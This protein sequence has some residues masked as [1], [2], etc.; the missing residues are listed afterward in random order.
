[1]L[2]LRLRPNKFLLLFIFFFILTGVFCASARRDIEEL[3]RR[4]REFAERSQ[5]KESSTNI[6]QEI[7]SALEETTTQPVSRFVSDTPQTLDQREQR[8]VDFHMRAANRNF[9]RRDYSR[10]INSLEQVFE[11]DPANAGGRFMRAVMAARNNEYTLA[12]H[13]ILIAKEKDSDNEKINLFINNLE[14]VKPRPTNMPSVPGIYRSMPSHMSEKIFD[15]IELLLND[16]C[17]IYIVE[18]SADQI[19]SLAGNSHRVNF[20][21]RFSRPP[22]EIDVVDLLS[23]AAGQRAI[24]ASKST[25]LLEYDFEFN[26]IDLPA[27][28]QNVRPAADLNAFVSTTAEELDVALRGSTETVLDNNVLQIVYDISARD[29]ETI[30]SFLRR[31]SPYAH[32]FKIKNMRLAGIPRSGQVIWRGDIKINFK[33]P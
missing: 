28:N 32:D 2:W 25:D 10:A 17:S 30:N 13:N 8:H 14:T 33:T 18:F 26:I 11:V 12:W 5:G 27:S 22:E 19:N 6:R 21:V 24:V 3:Q 16:R 7:E 20:Q 1:M 29:F 4:A 15:V 31:L 9:M 23:R